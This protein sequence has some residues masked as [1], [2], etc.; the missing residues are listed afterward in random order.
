MG[1]TLDVIKTRSSSRKFLDKLVPDEVIEKIVE[2]GTYA[3][4]GSGRQSPL[5]VVVNNKEVRDKLSAMNQAFLGEA[6]AG[7][8]PFYGAQQV[9]AVLADKSRARTGV[10]DGSI[11]MANMMLACE[12]LGVGSCWIHRAKETFESEE[13]K[14]ILK[15]AGIEGDIEGVG[16]LIIG[17]DDNGKREKAPRKEGYVTWIR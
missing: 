11:V 7:K 8:D 6:W 5:I 1:N 17:Y 3:A 14:E 16:F 12:E 13:G 15:K 10:Y 9:I 4:T 2:A